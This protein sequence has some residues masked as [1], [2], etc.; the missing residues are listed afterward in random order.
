L[1]K[2]SGRTD[3]EA[4]AYRKDKTFKPTTAALVARQFGASRNAFGSSRRYLGCGKQPRFALGKLRTRDD[5]PDD[6]QRHERLRS[7]R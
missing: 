6:E 1:E 2:V 3:P 5:R 7:A 4:V